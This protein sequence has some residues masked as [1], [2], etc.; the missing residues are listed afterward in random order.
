MTPRAVTRM[1]IRPG[2]TAHAATQPISCLGTVSPVKTVVRSAGGGTWHVDHHAGATTSDEE[3][4]SR[5]GR[6]GIHPAMQL[7]GPPM[8][9]CPPVAFGKSALVRDS[10]MC[11]GQPLL[12]SAAARPDPP[13]FGAGCCTRCCTR[14]PGEEDEA[15]DNGATLTG[16]IPGAHRHVVPG[17]GGA[18]LRTHAR[19]KLDTLVG[20]DRSADPS[21]PREAVTRLGGRQRRAEHA[22]P[23]LATST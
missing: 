10:A 2:P 16:R 23:A 11:A 18:V 22:V 8:A 13:L 21:G 5:A 9:T 7:R 3:R 20:R 15:P 4:R 6:S 19:P 17:I 12:T 1:S 14:P